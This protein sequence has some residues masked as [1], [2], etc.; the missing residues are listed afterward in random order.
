MFASKRL[1]KVITSVPL[2]EGSTNSCHSITSAITAIDS[3]GDDV[4]IC[5]TG[6]LVDSSL[7]AMRRSVLGHACHG[8]Q[9]HPGLILDRFRG[10]ALVELLDTVKAW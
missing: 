1:P 4:Y 8:S 3:Q 7:E 10:G 9:H 5:T 2:Q 6:H